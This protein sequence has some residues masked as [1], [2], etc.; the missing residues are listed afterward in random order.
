M[1]DAIRTTVRGVELVLCK[2]SWANEPGPDLWMPDSFGWSGPS[3]PRPI[4][5]WEDI[6]KK[7]EVA[8]QV[9]AGF[10]VWDIS[11]DRPK[12]WN[13]RPAVFRTGGQIKGLRYHQDS[14]RM[15][16]TRNGSDP[17]SLYRIEMAKCA[18]VT[19]EVEAAIEHARAKHAAAVEAR[20]EWEAAWKAIP[21]LTVE[22]WSTLPEKP[23]K[24]W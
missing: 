22:Q 14:V 9:E 1:S 11:D 13:K 6:I 12:Y 24:E 7:W 16:Q 23:G 15:V 18:P 20:K 19:P 3:A 5:E 8:R 2:K 10:E 21:R 17:D 4:H